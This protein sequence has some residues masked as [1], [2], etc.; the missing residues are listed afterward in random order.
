MSFL[1]ITD[2]AKRDFIV[3]EYLKTKDN[4]RKNY[5]TERT[6][7]LGAQRELTKLFKPVIETQKTVVKDL[8]KD[9]SKE[10]T[11]PITSALL[12]ITEGVQKAVEL[13]KYPSI[14]AAE[15]EEGDVSDTSILYLGDIASN[16]LRQ[17]ASKEGV[18][19]TFGLYDKGGVF[20]IGDSPV[21]ILD[22]NITIK[23]KEYEG[24]PGLWELLIMKRPNNTI[25]T[26]EDLANY[27]KILHDTNAMKH[28]HNPKSMKPKSSKGQKYKEIIRPIWDDIYSG[29]SYLTSGNGVKRSE[30]TLSAAKTTV[31]PS[32]PNA[33]IERL[34]LLLASEQAG[35]TG[36]RNELVS[37]CD[38]L[39][40]QDVIEK[41][42][43]KKL[44]LAL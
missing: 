3:Q 12:P 26:P 23:G 14:K 24:T 2:P 13:A 10:V 34:D 15:E 1:K 31:I 25:Y 33:L 43:Y 17:F 42:T 39:R 7:E 32:D 20:Y 6:G 29:Y 5:I 8:S 16:Y 4:V 9:L 30:T 28:N 18:D 21:E 41:E 44:M 35:N 11:Q 19:K 37:I 40:R 36:V 27:A 22:N 38:E